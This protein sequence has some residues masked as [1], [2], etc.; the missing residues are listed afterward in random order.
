MSGSHFLF[1]F[2]CTFQLFHR[3]FSLKRLHETPH[4]TSSPAP[5]HIPPDTRQIRGYIC[6]PCLSAAHA[7]L[8]Q[9]RALWKG[10]CAICTNHPG[11]SLTCGRPANDICPPA[12]A[13]ASDRTS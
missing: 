10:V 5:F 8:D 6:H 9:N 12:S 13:E 1:P 4:Y 7:R 2:I 11:R 3:R